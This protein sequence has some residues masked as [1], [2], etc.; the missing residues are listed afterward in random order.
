MIHELRTYGVL[1][2]KVADYLEVFG[3][4]GR[5][6]RGD[7]FGKLVGYFATELGPLN[8]ILHMWEFADLAARTEARAGLAKDERW[9][10]EYIPRSQALLSWQENMIL[11]PMD[12]YPL[13]PTTG[14]SI[15]E[16]RAYRFLPGKI[17]EWARL[18]REGLPIREK[19]SSPVGFWQVEVGPLNTVVHLWPYK[20]AQHRTEVRKAVAADPAWQALLGRLYPLIQ[21]QESKVLVP[22]SFSPLR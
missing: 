8:Q 14:M 18:A 15:Y 11:S 19:Y 6:V 20:D 3:T 9:V 1:P 2:G 10:K 13:K 17:P 5:P 7:R 22:A 16:L 4:V 21:H 12:W